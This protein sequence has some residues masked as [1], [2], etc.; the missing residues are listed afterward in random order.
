MVRVRVTVV[1]AIPVVKVLSILMSSEGTVF[2]SMNIVIR[3]VVDR[4][5]VDWFMLD[6][7]VVDL[8]VIDWLLMGWDKVRWSIEMIERDLVTHLLSKED[9]RESETYRVSELVVVLVLPLCH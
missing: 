4:F 2:W 7:L 1:I 9:L 8:L 3:T 5:M 6:W